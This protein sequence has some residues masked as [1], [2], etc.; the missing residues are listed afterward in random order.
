VFHV[1]DGNK[2]LAYRR[3]GGADD[4]V[5]VVANFANRRYTRYDIGLPKGGT[6]RVRV[7][8][9]D[10]KY[11]TDFGGSSSADIQALSQ[12]RDGQ[13]FTGPVALGAYS[14]VILTR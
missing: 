3:W 12:P 11:S 7:N 2:V 5:V 9:D 14:V 8:T 13:P 10:L 4:D 1:H 6:W